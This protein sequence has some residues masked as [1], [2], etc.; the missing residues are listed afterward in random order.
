MHNAISTDP[1]AT[2]DE[3]DIVYSPI[4]DQPAA[5]ATL[6]SK[7][8]FGD[9][10]ARMET[11][12]EDI[13]YSTCRRDAPNN[14]FVASFYSA[15]SS[16]TGFKVDGKLGGTWQL[17][18][19]TTGDGED[20]TWGHMSSLQKKT[21]DLSYAGAGI[22]PAFSSMNGVKYV[23]IVRTTPPAAEGVYELVDVLG[24][25]LEQTIQGCGETA[26]YDQTPSTTKWTAQYSGKKISGDIDG[27][28]TRGQSLNGAPYLFICGVNMEGDKDHSNL[29]FTDKTGM[30]GNGWGDNWHAGEQYGT[31][32]SL[33][34]AD[35]LNDA[36]WSA[37][38]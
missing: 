31:L 22:F 1:V 36:G 6:L 35:K 25:S 13:M 23:K 5:C 14:V 30:R 16:I 37:I 26:D 28:D 19:R 11:G 17:A 10:E 8:S 33:F 24:Q 15:T 21:A 32:W 27:S 12:V 7:C 2:S 29:A 20:A 18:V 3:W 9:Y 38:G 34:S 4:A